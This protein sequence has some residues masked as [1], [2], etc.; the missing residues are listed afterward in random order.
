MQSSASLPFR[1]TL[2]FTSWPEDQVVGLGIDGGAMH[3][4]FI[5][6]VKE[7]DFLR[8]GTAKPIMTLS[9]ADSSA[10]WNSVVEHDLTIFR[11]ISN[12]LL[13]SPSSPFRNVPLR[14][15]IPS[16]DPQNPA[17]KTLQGLV[18][19]TVPGA[20]GR[21]QP[22]TLGGALNSLA[23]SI[24]PSRRVP[25]LARPV[26]QGIVV[27]MTAPV[28]ELCRSAACPDGWLCVVVRMVG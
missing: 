23:P 7:A 22:Q 13:P 9:K 16:P 14:I 17:I 24:F 28:E 8:S 19:P 20:T 26:V 1:L 25:V 5:N 11:R 3:D 10:L 4:A 6:S 2:H 15:Y 18:G 12:I 21:G 27:P